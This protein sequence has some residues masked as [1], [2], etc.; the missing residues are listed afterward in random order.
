[1]PKTLTGASQ[2][3]VKATAVVPIAGELSSAARFE[4]IIQDILNNDQTLG[5]QIA[6]ATLSITTGTGID[7]ANTGT[8]SGSVTL[9]LSDGGVTTVKIANDAVTEAKLDMHNSPADGQILTYDTTNGMQWETPPSTTPPDG[10]VTEAKIASNAV[11]ASKIAA[12]AVGAS[13]IAAGAVNSEKVAA[14]AITEAKL[15]ISNAPTD[16]QV[17]TYKDGTDQLTWATASG[18]DSLTIITG[19]NAALN[20]ATS[21][22][23]TRFVIDANGLQ[24]YRIGRLVFFRMTGRAHISGSGSVTHS[25]TWD[26]TPLPFGTALDQAAGTVSDYTS[27]VEFTATRVQIVSNRV[28]IQLTS[29]TPIKNQNIDVVGRYLANA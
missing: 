12:N 17:L 21:T 28:R 13:E 20:A 5:T 14:E 10:S 26:L 8:S 29:T 16:G 23:G 18:G 9:S 24:A 27:S 6:N 22:T 25:G 2:S 1:M 11:T 4:R 19:W 15:D 7:G 3:A